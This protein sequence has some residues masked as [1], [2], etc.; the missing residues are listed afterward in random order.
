[1]TLIHK[2]SAAG[3]LAYILDGN[4]QICTSND[5]SSGVWL[6]ENFYESDPKNNGAIFIPFKQ[7]SG[8]QETTI[9]MTHQNFSDIDTFMW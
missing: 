9:I 6:N 2:P 5:G 1:L 4:N 3:H 7:D 8:S